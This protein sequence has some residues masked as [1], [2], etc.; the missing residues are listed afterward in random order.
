[1]KR[2]KLC[3]HCGR[4]VLK[5]S[6]FCPYCGFDLGKTVC[7]NCLK[8]IELSLDTCPYCG[9][10]VR[11]EVI[12]PLVLKNIEDERYKIIEVKEDYT[13]LKENK[14]TLEKYKPANIEDFFYTTQGLYYDVIYLDDDKKV[15]VLLPTH[16]IIQLDDYWD[17]LKDEERLKLIFGITNIFLKHQKI[18]ISQK[19]ILFDADGRLIINVSENEREGYLNTVEWLK[20]FLKLLKVSDDSMF[21]NMVNSQEF[22]GIQNVNELVNFLYAY[23]SS[24]TPIDIES[25]A[26]TSPG[27]VRGVNED[28]YVVAEYCKRGFNGLTP[29]FIKSALFVIS[30]GMGGHRGGEEASK[31]IVKVTTEEILAYLTKEHV[32]FDLVP[33]IKRAISRANAIVYQKNAGAYVEREKMGATIAGILIVDDELWYF[34]LGDS[35]IMFFDGKSLLKV[36]VDD[37]LLTNKKALTQAV[38]VMPFDNLMPHIAR[39][40]IEKELIFLICSDGL[41]DLVKFSEIED[42]L[43]KNSPKAAAQLLLSIA[44]DRGGIDNITIIIGKVRRKKLF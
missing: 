40:K 18:Y 41:T 17:M 44:L 22:K 6:A 19:P 37:V 42:A 38:G 16:P 27:L 23:I 15:P 32:F 13:V 14:I 3:P 26:I 29:N 28:N 21:Y 10:Q 12:V 1:M 34:N 24:F 31:L 43:R 2:R 7:E 5:N 8:K 33:V 39:Y 30:D 35:P 25:F 20:F 11:K 9:T 36:S 4:Q